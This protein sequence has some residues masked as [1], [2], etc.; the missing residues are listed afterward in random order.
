MRDGEFGL[1]SG[2]L[3]QGKYNRVWY[4]ETPPPDELAFDSETFLITKDKAEELRAP[5]EEKKE[6]I[7]TPT[8][9]PST[10]PPEPDQPPKLSEPR[11]IAQKPLGLAEKKK[12]RLR[13]NIPFE[14]WNP[15]GVRILPKIQPGEGLNLAIDLTVEVDSTRAESFEADLNQ[16]LADLR[17]DEQVKLE[18]G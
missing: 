16:A 1:A 17:L 11:S 7:G 9:G 12:V 14:N 4:K 2:D 13:G 6:P 3:G 15:F 5:K 18:E 10:D 8:G